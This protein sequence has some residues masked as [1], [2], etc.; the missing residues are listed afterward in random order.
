MS[1]GELLRAAAVLLAGLGLALLVVAMGWTDDVAG[2]L[3]P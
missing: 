2:A 3:T 1:A